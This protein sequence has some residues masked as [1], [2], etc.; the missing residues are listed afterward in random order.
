[1]WPLYHDHFAWL[2]EVAPRYA[3]ADAGEALRHL[4]FAA[5][6]ETP[7]IKKLIFLSIRC[8]HCHAGAGAAG[9]GIPKKDKALDVFGFQMQWLRAVQQRSGH[10]TVE[11]TVR[12]VCDYYRKMTSDSARAEAELFW[13]SRENVPV[14]KTMKRV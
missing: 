4:V 6:A 14:S 9:G 10:P 7:Q 12:I 3:F 11:K 8:G 5:N 2:D 1:M 13:R